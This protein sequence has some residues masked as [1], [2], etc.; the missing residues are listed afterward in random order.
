MDM[1]PKESNHGAVTLSSETAV[2]ST[3]PA[4]EIRTKTDA[5]ALRVWMLADD[6]PGHTT[7]ILG[8]AAPL[9]WPAETKHLRFTPLNRLPNRLL[10]ASRITLNS[11]R[12]SPL[13]PPW[14]D[15]VIAMGRRTA[16]VARW[17]KRQSHGR[18]RLVHLGRK[19]VNDPHGFDLMVSCAHFNLPENPRRIEITVPPTQ[20][21]ETSLAAAAGQWPD[22]YAN[23]PQ[24]HVALL[25]GGDTAQHRL[26]ADT[27]RRIAREATD[28]VAA[29]GGILT[30][31]TSRRTSAAAIAAFK[32]TLKSAGNLHLWRPESRDNPYLGYLAAADLLIVTGE[33]ESM[34]AEAAAT[35]KPLYIYP[36]PEAA[37]GPKA[38]LAEAM[39]R[40]V[41]V[42][43]H[44]AFS[45]VC[46]RLIRN[47]WISPPRD[48]TL[49]H[50]QMIEQGVARPFRAPLALWQPARL[51]DMEQVLARVRGLFPDLKAPNLEAPDLAI[52]NLAA[53]RRQSP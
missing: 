4:G 27:A 3:P 14:P 18:T 6:R 40:G 26:G 17:I 48:L 21:N 20:V 8:I 19:G 32:E 31:V 42:S 10:G 23:Q 1:T 9:G 51:D 33:S 15:L 38:R 44:G 47:G 22:L 28:A 35:G 24:P 30:I 2:S 50:R 11:R 52:P 36:L 7:Q 5:P 39:V 53:A 25:V 49:M 37:R 34:L 16:P 12:S 41:T 13:A 45:R 29:L 46:A 43:P